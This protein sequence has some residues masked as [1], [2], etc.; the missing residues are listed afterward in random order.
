MV[1]KGLIGYVL[2]IML[3]ISAL[4]N[5]VLGARLLAEKV[6]D[7]E[8]TERSWKYQNL[9]NGSDGFFA[10]INREVPS[11]PDPLHNNISA[12]ISLLMVKKFGEVQSE[13]MIEKMRDCC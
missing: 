8:K 13:H 7:E 6:E 3:S 1:S 2:L 9:D 5:G 11:C 10:T 12:K 4:K